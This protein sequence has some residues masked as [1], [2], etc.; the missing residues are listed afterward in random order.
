MPID[1]EE[2]NKI[3]SARN[4]QDTAWKEILDAYF[5]D[6]IHYCLPDLASCI[7]WEKPLCL[8]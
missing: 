5:K 4:E 3:K 8:A 1:N 2:E 6:F 7:D